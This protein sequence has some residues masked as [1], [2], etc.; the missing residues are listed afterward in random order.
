MMIFYEMV[1]ALECILFVSEEPLELNKIAGVLAT[2][3]ETAKEALG[4]LRH[5]LAE[6]KSGLQLVEL[7]G[8]YSL[9]SRQEYAGYVERLLH[10]PAN[11]GLSRAALEVLSIIAF[12]Q[13]VTRPEIED[14][15]GV[16]SDSALGTLVERGLVKEAGRKECPGRPRL[17]VTTKDFLA[18]FGFE[19]ADDIPKEESFKTEAL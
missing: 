9:A 3:V 4:Q 18:Y 13:P 7:S 1:A 2:D 17:Y 14:L 10:P 11:P 12:R 8:G 15:R 16:S 19:S 5:H 6:R